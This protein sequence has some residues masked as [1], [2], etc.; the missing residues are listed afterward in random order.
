MLIKTARESKVRQLLVNR[1]FMIV[2]TPNS[3]S[4]IKHLKAT[5][6]A[7]GTVWS[8]KD[9][10]SRRENLIKKGWSHTDPHLLSRGRWSLVVDQMCSP[11]LLLAQTL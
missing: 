2:C 6:Q 1:G 7:F 9:T 8:S 11:L 3:P 10:V 5:D 4:G